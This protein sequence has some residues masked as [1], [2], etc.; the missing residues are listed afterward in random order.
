MQYKE[1]FVTAR[2]FFLQNKNYEDTKTPDKYFKELPR[3]QIRTFLG[4]IKIL[5]LK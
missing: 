3:E 4:K 1:L 2:C 5:C